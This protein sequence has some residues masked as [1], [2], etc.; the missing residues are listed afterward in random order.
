MYKFFF[1][2]RHSFFGLKVMM[3]PRPDHVFDKRSQTR[4]E[5]NLHIHKHSSL[6]MRQGIFQVSIFFI[7][8][9]G[10]TFFS[11]SIFFFRGT[12]SRFQPHFEANDRRRTPGGLLRHAAGN[13]SSQVGGKKVFWKL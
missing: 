9:A 1:G 13:G 12:V 6:A 2:R 11:L 3:G 4:V 8:G 10:R 7:V 5:N